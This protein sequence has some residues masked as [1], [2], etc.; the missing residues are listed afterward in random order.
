MSAKSVNWFLRNMKLPS[1]HERNCSEGALHHMSPACYYTRLLAKFQPC[2]PIGSS[3]TWNYLLRMRKTVKTKC[4]ITYR[5]KAIINAHLQKNSAK[6]S[7]W[8]PRFMTLPTAHAQNLAALKIHMIKLFHYPLH[9]LA[10][11]QPNPTVGC[12]DRP[13]EVTV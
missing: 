11:F 13:L 2:R 8:R 5:L 6:S 9:L 3:K 12:W 4:Y 10:K 1:A 7:D